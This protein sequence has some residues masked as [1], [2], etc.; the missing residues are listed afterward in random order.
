[1]DRPT[2]ETDTFTNTNIELTLRCSALWLTSLQS[3]MWPW[4]LLFSN[5]MVM[6]L[7]TLDSPS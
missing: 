7:V 1:M 2:K 4:P 6:R 5:F 3:F